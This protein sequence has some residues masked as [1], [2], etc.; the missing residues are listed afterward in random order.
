MLA[1]EGSVTVQVTLCSQCCRHGVLAACACW[2]GLTARQQCMAFR[3]QA[4]LEVTAG[5]P[6]PC[7]LLDAGTAV[8]AL[9]TRQLEP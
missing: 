8:Y 2:N 4:G 7:R 5:Q 6:R 1:G 3:A 9:L